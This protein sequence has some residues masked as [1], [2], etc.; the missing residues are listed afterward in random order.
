MASKEHFPLPYRQYRGYITFFNVLMLGSL[1][2]A[3]LITLWGGALSWRELVTTVMLL[4]QAGLYL[5]LLLGPPEWPASQRVVILYFVACLAL[6][7]IES[8]LTPTIWWLGF[9]YV[10]Q[11]FGLLPLWGALAGTAFAALVMYRFLLA[12]E[13]MSASD[14]TLLYGI[15]A[16]WIPIL[17]IF[18]FVNQL[19]HTNQERGKLISE[20]EATQQEL[21]AAQAR[22]A[23]LAVLRE[24]ERLARDLHDSLGHALVA[25]SVQLE[26]VQRLYRVDPERASAQID[27]LKTLTRS[28][29]EALRRS[30]AGLRAP[31]LGDR[32]LRPALQALCADFGERVGMTVTCDLDDCTD[33]LRPALAETL[34]RVI[35][36]ALT[37]VEKHAEADCVVV[38]LICKPTAVLLRVTDNGVGLPED[39]EAGPNHFGLRGMRERVTGLGGTLTLYNDNG[40]VVEAHLPVIRS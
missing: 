39:V 40:A 28:S 30:I 17:V 23:E 15:A 32:D 19:M 7:A 3:L 27:E 16:Q 14:V 35:Q 29:M 24:R 18:V 11:M 37:N 1:A 12:P 34:W 26:A 20:L 4:V 9:A 36:E 25:I 2:T 6:W 10:G 13:A 33:D 21:R 31:G 8:W 22:E 5:W 38:H